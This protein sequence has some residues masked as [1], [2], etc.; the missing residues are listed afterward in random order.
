MDGWTYRVDNTGPDGSTFV[1]AN[2]TFSGPNALDGETSNA[3]AATPWPIGTYVFPITLISFE[4]WYQ[5]SSVLLTWRT[6]LE[7]ENDYMSVERSAD[8]WTYESIGR[9]SGQGTTYEEHSYTFVDEQPLPGANYYRLCQVDFDGSKTYY[10]PISVIA[11]GSWS[12][13]PSPAEDRLY[14]RST[15][16]S[17]RLKGPLDYRICDAQGL[18]RLQ[19]R[20]DPEL[21]E[22]EISLKDLPAGLY[23]LHWQQSGAVGLLRFVKK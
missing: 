6:A 18:V 5:V 7:L 4:G 15:S 20:L 22:A 11:E 13:F 12:I 8:G 16:T 3:T 14:L 9:V 23:L 2:W 17:K 21:R 19:G 1:L 10:S